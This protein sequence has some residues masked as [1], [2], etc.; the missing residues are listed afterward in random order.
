MAEG[1]SEFLVCTK[2]EIHHYFLEVLTMTLSMTTRS[3]SDIY[4]YAKQALDLL[5]PNHP[6]YEE[7][8]QLLLEQVNDE[9]ET[10]ANSRSN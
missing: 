8:R 5:S 7:I 4:S 1:E 2:D 6:H 3:T 9:L 10:Y